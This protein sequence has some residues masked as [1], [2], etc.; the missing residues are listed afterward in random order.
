MLR[1]RLHPAGLAARV[2]AAYGLHD[3]RCQLLTATMR[4][5]YAVTSTRGRHVLFVYPH[6]HR[7][8]E[9]V[10]A[11]WDFVAHLARGGVRVAPA[12][13][14]AD[15]EIVLTF[16]APEGE[17]FGV[18]GEWMEGETL[19]RRSTPDAAGR[20]GH[21]VARI[22]LLA[23]AL[24]SALPRP[25][26]DPA[27]IVRDAAAAAE[28][29]LGDRPHVAI[30]VRRAAERVL[31]RVDALVP[32]PATRGIIHGDVI[33]AN[34]LLAADGSVGV[35]DF[36]LCGPGWRAYDV[37]SYLL[38]IRGT[39]DEPALRRAFLAGYQRARPLAEGEHAL[40]PLFEAVRALFSI[41]IPAGNVDAWGRAY[42][43]AVLDGTLPQ[44]GRLLDQVSG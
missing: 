30:L 24:P 21:A 38:T 1:S 37:A 31:P 35:I 23:D 3:V 41:G 11:E 8:R 33:R 14:A 18:L 34:A 44:L 40:L 2:A 26:S 16:Q 10:L 13:P 27:A 15:G 32:S 12:V 25:A 4:D 42:L 17:R 22:H 19:R 28:A 5:V 39:P 29:A 43:D 7:T 20:Y 9:E 6:A 36:D